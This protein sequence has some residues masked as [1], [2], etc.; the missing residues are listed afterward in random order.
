MLLKRNIG[1]SFVTRGS[2]GIPE[3]LTQVPPRRPTMGSLPFPNPGQ[4]KTTTRTAGTSDKA[5]DNA[6]V[7]T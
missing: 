3:A 2:D 6:R 7:G 5:F 1:F 4:H